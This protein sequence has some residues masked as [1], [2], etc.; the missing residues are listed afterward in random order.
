MKIKFI[1]LI[2]HQLVV[3]S[4]TLCQNVQESTEKS[5]VKQCSK[6]LFEG[7]SSV[8]QTSKRAAQLFPSVTAVEKMVDAIIEVS[9]IV[10]DLK[11]S[12][13]KTK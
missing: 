2:A 5:H 1:I 12:V 13:L 8:V 7:I 11:T 3:I 6:A 10:N 4:D 9:H